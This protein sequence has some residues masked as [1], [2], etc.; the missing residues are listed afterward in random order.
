M[1]H[2]AGKQCVLVAKTDKPVRML[3]A[4]EVVRQG[5]SL[6]IPSMD[7]KL[8]PGNMGSCT[9][10]EVASSTLERLLTKMSNPDM[11]LKIKSLTPTSVTD[12]TLEIPEP[13]MNSPCVI[14]QMALASK[15]R[16][17]MRLIAC[18]RTLLVVDDANVP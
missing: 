7:L 8:M 9:K 11:F 16:R 12:G 17:A 18:K 1:K 10:R 6:L 14:A 15:A 13:H 5:R 4:E 2:M 3:T